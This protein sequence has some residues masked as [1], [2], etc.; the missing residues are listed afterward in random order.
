MSSNVENKK[1]FTSRPSDLQTLCL[2]I[3]LVYSWEYWIYGIIA[4]NRLSRYIIYLFSRLH[5]FLQTWRSTHKTLFIFHVTRHV[6]PDFYLFHNFWK[7]K[8]SQVSPTHTAKLFGFW[9]NFTFF[10]YLS[11]YVLELSCILLSIMSRKLQNLTRE[12][13]FD[14][15]Y[16]TL[17]K[18]SFRTSFRSSLYV[19]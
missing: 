18:F 1:S 14:T 17:Y 6:S 7:G 19:L 10:E 13:I 9:Y 4:S 2:G 8:N 11:T 5:Y 12:L 3:S 15:A 16:S